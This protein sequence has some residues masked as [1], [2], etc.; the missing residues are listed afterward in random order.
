M[1]DCQHLDTRPALLTIYKWGFGDQ[2]VILQSDH[3]IILSDGQVT[4]CWTIVPT[5][6]QAQFWDYRLLRTW[7][8]SAG[9]MY[10]YRAGVLEII[11]WWSYN[12][13]IRSDDQ[14]IQSDDQIRL[15]DDQVARWWTIV[16]TWIQTQC[17]QSFILLMT[18]RTSHNQMV[19]R[20]YNQMISSDCQ[21]ER[22][23]TIV[24]TWI[25][26]QCCQRVIVMIRWHS[27]FSTS[28]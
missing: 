4:R 17:C 2:T 19:I 12:Q 7:W 22:C 28:F 27:W 14:I 21:V 20:L 24:P 6:R 25:Q 13:T 5:W 11:I 18:W 1:D 8:P 9:T 15:S 16:P 10:Y 3:Q 26:A 23:W